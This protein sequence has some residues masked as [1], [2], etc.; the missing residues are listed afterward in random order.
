MV[1][2]SLNYGIYCFCQ[3]HHRVHRGGSLEN[4]LIKLWYMSHLTMI[5]F[6]SVKSIIEFLEE[7][8]WRV[9]H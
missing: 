3:G 5:Y 2:V 6:V 4:V 9:S 8:V 7:E 1:Y